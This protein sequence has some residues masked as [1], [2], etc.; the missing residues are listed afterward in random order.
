[1]TKCRR[2]ISCESVAEKQKPRKSKRIL[3]RVILKNYTLFAF[4]Y[5]IARC[6][7]A[8]ILCCAAL[9]R[10]YTVL[11]GA[12][13]LLYCIARRYTALYCIAWRYTVYCIVRRYTAMVSLVSSSSVT[14]LRVETTSPVLLSISAAQ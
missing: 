1:M 13:P 9:Y 4:L 8:F 5:C 7:T 6:Y 2:G 12:I 14:L 11:R 10:F 3:S